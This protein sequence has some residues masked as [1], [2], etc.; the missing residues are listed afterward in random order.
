MR[1]AMLL[2][3]VIS[4]HAQWPAPKSTDDAFQFVQSRRA[5]AEKLW[6]KGDP[7]AIAMLDD[8]QKYLDQPLVRDLAAGNVYLSSRRSNLL[9]DYSEAYAIQK[10]VADS[11]RFLEKFA[12]ANE[13]P[14][15]A[16]AIEE[17]KHFDILRADPRYAAALAKM[18]RYD[19]FWDSAAL[20]TPFRDNLSDPEKLA[21]L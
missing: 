9:L 1:L 11:L 21:G 5:A 15:M 10:K 4:C 12:D 16:K 3:T 13:V 2:L 8:L 6:T 7:A 19:H 18:G 17:E 20:N 14:G